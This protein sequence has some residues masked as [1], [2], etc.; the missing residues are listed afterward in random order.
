MKVVLLEDVKKLGKKGDIVNVSDGYAR[1]FLI[2]HGLALEGSKGNIQAA[3]EEVVVK[4]QRDDREEEQAQKLADKLKSVT[5]TIPAKAGEKGRLF[6]SIT[7]KDIT[8]VLRGQGFDID[9]RKIELPG[10]IKTL[11]TYKIH[12]KLY[13]GISAVLDMSVVDAS[14]E[15]D[16]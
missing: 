10:V 6:G 2:P 5:I 15:G 12:I 13:P 16:K 11:G 3:M 14:V 9:R 8:E 4:Q 7:S 1:N